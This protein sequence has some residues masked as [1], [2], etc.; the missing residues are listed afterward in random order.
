MP[1]PD[2]L[3]LMCERDVLARRMRH[4]DDE[5]RKASTEW[6]RAN[7]YFFTVRPEQIRATLL[8]RAAS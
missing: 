6:S 8:G 3:T 2:L 7:G 4:L 5:I 1:K